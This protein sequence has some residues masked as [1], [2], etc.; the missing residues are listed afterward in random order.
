V[1]FFVSSTTSSFRPERSEVEKPAVECDPSRYVF[2]KNISALSVAKAKPQVS[3]LRFHFVKPPV[4]MTK[5]CR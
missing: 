5:L 1:I 3:P 2:S 4:E